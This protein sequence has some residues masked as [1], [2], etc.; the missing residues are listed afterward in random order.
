MYK[1]TSDLRNN[2]NKLMIEYVCATLPSRPEA[3]HRHI[4][5]LYLAHTLVCHQSALPHCLKALLIVLTLQHFT[6]WNPA[7]LSLVEW[8]ILAFQY[9]SLA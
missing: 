4:R 5:T 1:Y 9:M 7:W 8:D 3:Q 2:A 6:S